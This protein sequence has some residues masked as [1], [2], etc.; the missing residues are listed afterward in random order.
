MNQISPQPQPQPASNT[1]RL[2]VWVLALG[3]ILGILFLGLAYLG[4]RSFLG[5]LAKA[6]PIQG[7][8]IVVDP[9]NAVEA[10]RIEHAAHAYLNRRL[11]E[12]GFDRP[13]IAPLRIE[14]SF[15]TT[16][17]LDYKQNDKTISVDEVRLELAFHDAAGK[18]LKTVVAAP[19]MYGQEEIKYD[20]E[21]E[22]NK[23]AYARAVS[24]IL[25][26]DLPSPTELRSKP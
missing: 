9:G 25:K 15:K 19:K 26:M 17:A 5:E 13:G 21:I 1:R 20:A 2:L 18:H 12:L 16:G 24:Q 22:L 8:T 11:R 14:V 23:T 7:V 3:A 4:I 10:E 6:D